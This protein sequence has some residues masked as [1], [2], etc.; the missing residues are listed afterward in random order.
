MSD[1]PDVTEEDADD[2]ATEDDTGETE[3]PFR[4]NPEHTYSAVEG[5]DEV[6][7]VRDQDEGEDEE[8]DS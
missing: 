7:V 8:P 4:A 2:E 6:R 1:E 3:R 5:D